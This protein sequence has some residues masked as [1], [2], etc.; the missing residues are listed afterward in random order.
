LSFAGV[1]NN[2]TLSAIEILPAAGNPSP[3]IQWQAV[4]PSPVDRAE[5]LGAVVNGKLYVLGGYFTDSQNRV[6]ARVRCDVYDPATNTWTQ[7]GDQPEA[8]THSGIA[9]D[10]SVI[11]MVGA[12]MGDH[13]GPGSTVVWKYDTATDTWE[14]GPDLPEARGAGGAAIVGRE[15]HFMGGMDESRT[16]DQGEHWA[17]DLDNPDAGWTSRAALPNPRNHVAA[18]NLGGKI[19]A[20]GGQHDQEAAQVAQSDVHCYDP[21]TDTWTQL[22]SLPAPRSHAGASTF[23]MGDRIIVLGGEIGYN[24]NQNT[25]YAYDPAANTWSLI[26]LLP[27]NRSTS[28]A[29]VIG[30]NRII[31]A[32]GNGPAETAET[33][34]GTLSP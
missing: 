19:Y 33:W 34:I 10:G 22:A 24:L 8:I 4:A 16:V 1:L 15:L 27:V 32:T 5:S 12:Y 7:L 21:L 2:A 18:V 26:G 9:V 14:R 20:I 3:N 29:G 13:P 31:T 28:V 25:V 23:V 6:R 30:V 17:L 11:W